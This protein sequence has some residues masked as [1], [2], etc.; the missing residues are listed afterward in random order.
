MLFLQIIGKLILYN[1]GPLPYI[2]MI[3]V[4]LGVAFSCLLYFL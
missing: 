3:E 4:Y 1:M 2:V